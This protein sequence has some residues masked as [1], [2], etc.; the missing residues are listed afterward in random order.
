MIRKTIIVTT[1]LLLAATCAFAAGSKK[2]EEPAK[3]A[4]SYN[5]GVDQMKAGDFAAAQKSFEAALAAKDDFAEAH[6]NLGFS[7]RKQGDAH[8]DKA[9]EHYNRALELNPKLAEAYMYRG[10]LYVLLG[11]E[12]KAKADHN[13]LAELD[14]EL[15]KALLQVIATGE[16]PEGTAGLAGTWTN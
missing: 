15:A 3:W 4:E 1:A 13:T 5:Q 2:K 6:N 10:V 9:L 8:R 16:E 14:G 12:A 11:D 7:L